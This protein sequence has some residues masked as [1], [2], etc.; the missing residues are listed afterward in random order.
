MADWTDWL[1]IFLS[2][3]AEILHQTDP[4]CH[5]FHAYLPCVWDHMQNYVH[6][7]A[8]MEIWKLGSICGNDEHGGEGTK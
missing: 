1:Q 2:F 4:F 7:W 8:G 6:N 3:H 5:A